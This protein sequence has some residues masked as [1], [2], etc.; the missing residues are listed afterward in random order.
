MTL[1]NWNNPTQFNGLESSE[2]TSTYLDH[3]W[4][5]TSSALHVSCGAALTLPITSETV[6]NVHCAGY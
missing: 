3:L 4:S 2:S 1:Q 5:N 6:T